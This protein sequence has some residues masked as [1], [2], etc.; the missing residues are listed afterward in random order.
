MSLGLGLGLWLKSYGGG[1]APTTQTPLEI[2]GSDLAGWWDVSNAAS[3]TVASG[4]LT[5]LANRASG[6]AMA[7][8]TA[9]SQPAYSATGFQSHVPGI[10]FDGADDCLTAAGLTVGT[11]EFAA[12]TFGQF[13]LTD[14]FPQLLM[15]Y[16][17]DGD[18]DDSGPGSA[19][20]FINGGDPGTLVTKQNG[21]SAVFTDGTLLRTQ[22]GVYMRFGTVGVGGG[23]LRLYCDRLQIGTAALTG[24]ALVS[25]GT[26]SWGAN[27]G[28]GLPWPGTFGEA[29]VLKRAP[30]DAEIEKLDN[31]FLRHWNRV[32]V[33]EGD[34]VTWA[35]PTGANIGYAYRYLPNASPIAFLMNMATPGIGFNNLGTD[36]FARAAAH[37]DTILPTNKAGKQYVLTVYTCN[38][39]GGITKTNDPWKLCY[40]RRAACPEAPR[41]AAAA[42]ASLR[43]SASVHHRRH[44]GRRHSP[45][46][47]QGHRLQVPVPPHDARNGLR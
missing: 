46:N 37:I 30:T 42:R 31:H 41:S 47:G 29:V 13:T 1:G 6:P 35:P 27:T 19:R 7:Q 8:A 9:A 15:Q 20:F 21:V 34:S 11:T 12:F 39:L 43:P 24:T 4:S 14:A 3:R 28:G 26:V 36:I 17:A 16:V 32:L 2:F 25:P 33:A 44:D 22:P 38:N 23:N 45:G 5:S 18:P 40:P 10:T